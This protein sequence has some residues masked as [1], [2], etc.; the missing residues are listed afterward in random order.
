MD[1]AERKKVI[2][3]FIEFLVVGVC[4]GVVEDLI[5]IHFATDAKITFQT[6]KIA[7]FV[8]VP[9]AIVAE[10]LVDLKI[11]KRIFLKK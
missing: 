4:M 10:L 11:F 9:F 2:V 6:F 3:H 8:A 7:F 1:S 5:A